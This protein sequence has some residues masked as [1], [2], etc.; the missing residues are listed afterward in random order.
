MR[1]DPK[2]TIAGY[3]ALLVRRALRQLDLHVEW[4]LGRLEAITGEGRA[5]VRVLAAAGLVE[6]T[7]KGYWS[8]T[9][10]GRALS[11]CDSRPAREARDGREG[12]GRVPGA[13][14]PR[15]SQTGLPRQGG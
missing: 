4:D 14:G 12:T 6:P 13:R 8:M 15:K 3:P 2:G 10:A 11:I 5:F 1:I 9:R 7:R